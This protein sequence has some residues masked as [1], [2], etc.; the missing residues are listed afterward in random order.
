[1]NDIENPWNSK[2]PADSYRKLFPVFPNYAAFDTVGIGEES[3]GLPKYASK[4]LRKNVLA[5]AIASKLGI[6]PAYAAK[7][8]LKDATIKEP[9][10]LGLTRKVDSIFNSGHEHFCNYVGSLKNNFGEP[11]TLDDLSNQFFYRN[12]AGLEAAKRLS[13]LGFLCEVAVILRSL[14]EQ[15]A[16]AAKLR[17]LPIETDLMKVR[18]VQCL[19]YFK[20]VEPGSARLYGLLS[21]YTHL[22][23]DHHTH[24]F[25][26]STD[27]IF[28]IWK[29]SV[30]RAYSTHLLF[31]TMLSVA[32]Y[33]RL[34]PP[35]PFSGVA[36]VVGKLSDFRQEI[37]R[38]SA[39][40]CDLLPTDTVLRQFDRAIQAQVEE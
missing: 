6:T 1:V 34:L 35:S 13:E 16:F 17:T 7:A 39:E 28:T 33:I 30:L 32:N 21:K 31:M 2:E 26:R 4:D 18:P 25:A 29:D 40:V 9:R 22:E 11:S 27:E 5:A 14:V 10:E 38:Y 20:S 23:Y 36:D 12:M 24:F 8:Y 19:N 37:A 3:I 15:F